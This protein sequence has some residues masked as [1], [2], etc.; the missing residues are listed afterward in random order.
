[1]WRLGFTWIWWLV[2]GKKIDLKNS[3]LVSHDLPDTFQYTTS[4]EGDIFEAF[5]DRVIYTTVVFEIFF[6]VVEIP[7]IKKLNDSISQK[8]DN[9]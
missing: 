6:K 9:E 7:A 1:M 4:G 5:F 8:I 2:T 3:Y